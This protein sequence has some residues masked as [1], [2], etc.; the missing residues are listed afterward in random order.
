[1]RSPQDVIIK[2]LVTE[3]AVN[4]AQ[5]DNKYSFIVN[6][7]ANKIEIKK[8]V[9]DLFKVKVLSVNTAVVKGKNKKVGKYTGHTATR[10]KAIV[11]LQQGDKIEIFEGLLS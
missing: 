8:A 2:P 1:M 4:R 7:Q 11:T 10:K 6:R 5:N 3:Q 9:E